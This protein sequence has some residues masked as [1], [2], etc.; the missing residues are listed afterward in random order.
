MSELDEGF[1]TDSPDGTTAWSS[2]LDAVVASAVRGF[3]AAALVEGVVT[4]DGTGRSAR[5]SRPRWAT[6]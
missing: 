2:P 4:A 6:P 1:I 3:D 5:S